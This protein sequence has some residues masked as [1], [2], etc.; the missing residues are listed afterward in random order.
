MKWSIAVLCASLFVAHAVLGQSNALIGTWE[1]FDIDEEG[2][3][4]LTILQFRADGTVIENDYYDDELACVFVSPYSVEGNILTIGR[5]LNWEV[6]PETGELEL[7]EDFQDE[8][9][10]LTFTVDGDQFEQSLNRPQ[11]L[12]LII[13]ELS[14]VT[15]E[16]LPQLKS[17]DIDAEEAS[18]EE[19][20]DALQAAS[21][22]EEDLLDL[23][24]LSLEEVIS[25][26]EEVLNLVFVFE[27]SE[28]AIV[29]PPGQYTLP[30]GATA[31][32]E[33]SWGQIK[34]RLAM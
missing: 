34:K 6:N 23:A 27:R 33:H 16:A 10:S 15:E 3:A 13:S 14:E 7:Y 19:I 5:G 11:A 26:F 20:L 21:G 8:E 24:E 4:S 25:R 1:F 29:I 2:D 28:H 31:I 32:E 18:L 17:L 30:D 12:D 22:L 9:F